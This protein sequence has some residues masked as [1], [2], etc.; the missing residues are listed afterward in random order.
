MIAFS[1]DSRV[2]VHHLPFWQPRS[3]ALLLLL[4]LLPGQ[5]PP[6]PAG[7]P[8]RTRV[9]SIPGRQRRRDRIPHGS[10]GRREVRHE[11][12]AHHLFEIYKIFKHWWVVWFFF[13]Q[14]GCCGRNPPP[15]AAAAARRAGRFTSTLAT[16]TQSPASKLPFYFLITAV[17]E[18]WAPS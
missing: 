4:L 3:S 5:R 16:S 2:P 9:P 13:P 17:M 8:G 18:E 1:L 14:S 12:I 6:P 15:A 7:L 11:V 10:G